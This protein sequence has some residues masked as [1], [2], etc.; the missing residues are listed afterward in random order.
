[1]YLIRTLLVTTGLECFFAISKVANVSGLYVYGSITA[2][3][4]LPKTNGGMDVITDYIKIGTEQMRH[5]Y[6]NYYNYFC[7]QVRHDLF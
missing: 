1:M 6:R 4:T 3:V 2:R 7:C 5:F